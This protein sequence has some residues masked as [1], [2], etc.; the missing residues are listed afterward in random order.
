MPQPASVSVIIVTYN[1][2]AT[3]TEALRA[4]SPANQPPVLETIVVDN[5][6]TD[7]TVAHIAA[8]FPQVKIIPSDRNRGF[9][10][11]CNLGANAAGGEYLLFVNPDLVLDQGAIEQLLLAMRTRPRAGVTAGR[12]RYPDGQ[13]Q[14]NCRHFPTISNL[15]FSRG[16]AIGRIFL[17]RLFRNSGYYTLP[18]YSEVTEVPAVAGTMMLI[19][20]DLF[21][22]AGG[23]DRRFFIYMEDTDLCLR[24]DMSGYKNL[25]VPQAGAVHGF[26]KGSSAGKFVRAWH[27]HQSLW[28]YFLKH[29]PNGFSLILLPVLLTVHLV[30][31]C[32]LPERKA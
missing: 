1:S 17:N 29:Y 8:E 11:G 32:L 16:S 9:A 22:L 20:R 10:Y 30:V 7:G 24:L 19:R 5:N 14:A 26:G 6:S 13:F 25:F 31:V 3:V 18:D 4:V 21:K 23:F 27:H 12:L 28:R 2:S 15:L